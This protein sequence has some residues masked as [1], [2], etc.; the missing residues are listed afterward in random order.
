MAEEGPTAPAGWYP[1]PDGT[2]RYWDGSAWAENTTYG[3]TDDPADADNYISDRFRR[4]AIPLVVLAVVLTAFGTAALMRRGDG[5]ERPSRFAPSVVTV[6]YEVE[7]T[8]R[9]ADVTLETPSG[10]SQQTPDVPLVSAASGE[11]G[12]RFTFPSG[13]FAYIA[14]QKK[15]AGGTITCRISVDG[16]VVSENTSSAAYGIAVCKGTI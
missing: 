10:T 5:D 4:R 15:G 16:R 3:A 6:T 2:Q 9:W 1:Q 11:R 7:G 8:V 12:L 14:A 13:S